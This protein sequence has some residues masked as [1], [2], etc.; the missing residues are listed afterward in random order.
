MNPVAIQ[1]RDVAERDIDHLL[2]EEMIANEGFR[3]W[4]CGKIG[5]SGPV[6]I[7]SAARSVLDATG[8]SD[9]EFTFGTLTGKVQVL[10][11]NKI[12]ALLQPRQAERYAERAATY[13]ASGEYARVL[14]VLIAPH[15]Y[16]SGSLG[17]DARVY[18]EDVFEFLR[19]GARKDARANYKLALLDVAL[20][21]A[22]SGWVSVPDEHST[23]LWH[24]YH[25][26]AT[27]VAP[28]L[29]MPKPG[30]K[31]ARSGFI[32]FKPRELP[33]GV[34]LIHKAPYGH[35]D[36]QWFG[37]AADVDTFQRRFGSR[38]EAGM[39]VAAAS[40]SLVLRCDIAP[41]SLTAPVED[42]VDVIRGAVASAQQLFDWYR[43]TVAPAGLA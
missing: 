5:V 12:D 6:T 33:K 10:L 2:L 37:R 31:P 24:R 40:K 16:S 21:R 43:R 9:L 42:S 28:Q 14:T 25:E 18:Y 4:I 30:N 38:L 19:E 15:R 39:S 29:R 20:F 17:F 7:Q 23:R 27:A 35:V 22:K 36:L 32:R 34:E 26:I 1:L 41:L 13:L 3:Q 8:E 11:E